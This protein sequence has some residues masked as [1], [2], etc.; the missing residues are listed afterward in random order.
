METVK[1]VVKSIIESLAIVFIM[2][3]VYAIIKIIA[4]FSPVLL[5]VL[6]SIFLLV[7]A[8]ICDKN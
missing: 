7:S 6:L 1:K 5:M 4:D 2:L 3:G 8:H